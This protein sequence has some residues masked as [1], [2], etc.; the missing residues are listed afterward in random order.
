MMFRLDEFR[1]STDIDQTYNLMNGQR[2]GKNSKG[3]KLQKVSFADNLENIREIPHD[4]LYSKADFYNLSLPPIPMNKYTPLSFRDPYAKGFS[5]RKLAKSQLYDN[6]DPF[7]LPYLPG[8]GILRQQ[9]K[10]PTKQKEYS[11]A[12]KSVLND[13]GFRVGSTL[14]FKY[15]DYIDLNDN[16]KKV[17]RHHGGTE[18]VT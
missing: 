5:T 14:H 16:K 11:R 15:S 18:Q 12:Q 4:D 7:K 17:K 2:K 8:G 9:Q 13:S 10:K 3:K 1:T 6:Y